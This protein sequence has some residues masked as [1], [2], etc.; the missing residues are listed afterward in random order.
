MFPCFSAKERVAV[1]IPNV[2]EMKITSG[3]E[4]LGEAKRGPRLG[5]EVPVPEPGLTKGLKSN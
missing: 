4:L 5:A 3:R 1:A 2:S